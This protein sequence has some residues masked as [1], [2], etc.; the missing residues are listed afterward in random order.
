MTAAKKFLFDVDFGLEKDASKTEKKQAIP[1][2]PRTLPK[3]SENEIEKIKEKHE[4]KGYSEGLAKGLKDANESINQK[5]KFTIEKILK[6]IESFYLLQEE[7]FLE[8]KKQ[9]LKV[10]L[11]IGKKLSLNLI[12]TQPSIEVEKFIEDSFDKVGLLLKYPEIEIHVSSEIFED[13]TKKIEKI[14]SSQDKKKVIVSV[15]PNNKMSISNCEIKWREGGLIRNY[16]EIEES[17]DTSIE[18]YIHSL[19]P[20]DQSQHLKEDNNAEVDA[21]TLNEKTKKNSEEIKE[22]GSTKSVRYED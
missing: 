14:N 17:I 18:R 5:T 7:K 6:H 22:V 13:I 15:I 19:T 2:D 3:Y 16:K 8:T 21:N 9:A 11:M 4:S 10:S 1:A 12:N 20:V